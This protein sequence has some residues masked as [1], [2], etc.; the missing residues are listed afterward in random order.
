MC[1]EF[2]KSLNYKPKIYKIKLLRDK[3]SIL[4]EIVLNSM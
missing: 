3:H 2:K 4:L 1:G